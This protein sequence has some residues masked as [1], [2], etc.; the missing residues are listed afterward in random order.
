MWMLPR[1]SFF[2][3]PRSM[4]PL[5]KSLLLR[6]LSAWVPWLT[7][8]SV[9]SMLACP[10]MS[11][12]VMMGTNPGLVV[13]AVVMVVAV[14]IGRMEASIIGRVSSDPVDQVVGAVGVVSRV[15]VR[16][17]GLSEPKGEGCAMDGEASSHHV[18]FLK[19][20]VWVCVEMANRFSSDDYLCRYLWKGQAL[21]SEKE[22]FIQDFQ[23]MR[24]IWSS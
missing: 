14:G 9:S 19:Y 10:R 8:T 7:P 6:M 1:A 24:M 5:F 13:G 16:V 4:S 21:S 22:G 3:G 18:F 15:E 11:V 2:L 17:K 23:L 12:I 20:W